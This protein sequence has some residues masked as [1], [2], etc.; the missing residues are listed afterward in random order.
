MDSIKFQIYNG[1]TF[2][3]AIY[4]DDRELGFIKRIP[5]NEFQTITANYNKP[6]IFD[7]SKFSD[8]VS[9]RE[10]WIFEVE[11]IHFWQTTKPKV[12][13]LVAASYKI[14]MFYEYKITPANYKDCILS[15]SYKENYI[16]G[17][18]QA[19]IVTNLIFKGEVV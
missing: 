2:G 5:A 12:E 19:L 13:S 4:F 3:T 17:S 18:E 6:V 15:K 7:I 11:I 1:S 8:Q 16:Y 14:R 9:T 10:R